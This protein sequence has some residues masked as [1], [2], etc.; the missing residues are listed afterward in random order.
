MDLP[1][2]IA[3]CSTISAAFDA[4]RLL[5]EADLPFVERVVQL[6]SQ[7]AELDD[8]EQAMAS[9]YRI[10]LDEQHPF[11]PDLADF[12]LQWAEQLREE[13]AVS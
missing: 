11:L 2:R 10:A 13:L 3:G 5:A 4:M 12:V 8:F 9:V 1:A 7:S 6:A